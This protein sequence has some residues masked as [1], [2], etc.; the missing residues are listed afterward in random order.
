MAGTV[1]L[2]DVELREAQRDYLD[3][4]D[5]EVRGAAGRGRWRSQPGAESLPN[6]PAGDPRAIGPRS[7]HPARVAS[8]AVE[9]SLVGDP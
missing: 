3:F 7:P 9:R 1:V 6:G 8:P 4:L 5:D 2:D